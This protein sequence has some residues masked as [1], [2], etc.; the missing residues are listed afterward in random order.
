ML[1]LTMALACTGSSTDG[2]D[3]TGDS[4]TPAPNA[5]SDAE[6]F[7][8]SGGD[9]LVATEAAELCV[10]GVTS[11][12]GLAELYRV[13]VVPGT[14][15]WPDTDGTSSYRLPV[16][17]SSRDGTTTELEVGEIERTTG[18]NSVETTYVQPFTLAGATRTLELD[19][20]AFGAE[21]PSPALDGL[22][23]RDGTDGTVSQA[24]SVCEEGAGCI[25]LSPCVTPQSGTDPETLDFARG[26]LS[27]YIDVV[28][29]GGVWIDPPRL[30]YKASGTLDDVAFDQ[31]DYD[32]L[33][34]RYAA[35]GLD[36]ELLVLFDAPIGDAC[37]LWG[38]YGR[39]GKQELHTIDCDGDRI[40][41]LGPVTVTGAGSTAR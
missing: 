39:A 6:S 26:E 33:G 25:S 31:I 19:V 30:L 32:R 23:A 10:L 17:V 34:Y 1:I 38:R 20:Y 5:C 24:L 18:A 9:T 16:C 22:M 27:L 28:L 36:R 37:G 12:A 2:P 21:P 11:V 40:D 14:Y 7:V 3:P 35:H 15:A 4:G 41:D 13:K 8:G 29:D